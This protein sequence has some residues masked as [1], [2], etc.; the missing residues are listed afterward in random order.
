MNN[1]YQNALDIMT[2]S[3]LSGIVL[4]FARDMRKINE[5]VRAQGGRTGAVNRHPV[6]RLYAEQIAW[7]AGAGSCSSHRS[8]L[9]A[10]DEC[11]RKAQ[12]QMVV[13]VVGRS[14]PIELN[15]SIK[16]HAGITAE[17]KEIE[18]HDES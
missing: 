8:Y 3:N 12:E 1:I 18:N 15:Q 5:E 9:R 11:E 2:A 4:Q 16:T 13:V 14:C 7:L 6:C 10:Y 17:Y